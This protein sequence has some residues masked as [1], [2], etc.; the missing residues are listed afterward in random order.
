MQQNS[1]KLRFSTLLNKDEALRII[2]IMLI[3]DKSYQTL[4]LRQIHTFYQSILYNNYILMLSENKP[5]AVIM[6]MGVPSDVKDDCLLRDRTPLVS[7]LVSKGD[8][9]YCIAFTSIE[10]GKL[11][12]LWRHFAKTYQD[13]DILIKRHFKRGKRQTSTIMLIRNQHRVKNFINL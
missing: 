8:S 5:V 4:P 6:W 10:P 12:N 13:Q 2:L 11:L 9:I 1:S 7:E 3:R